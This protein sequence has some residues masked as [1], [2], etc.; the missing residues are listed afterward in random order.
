M[1]EGW[2]DGSRETFSQNSHILSMDEAVSPSDDAVQALVYVIN[3]QMEPS[4][5]DIAHGAYESG[6]NNLP[7]AVEITDHEEGGDLQNTQNDGSCNKKRRRPE[8]WR[9]NVEKRKRQ[10]GQEYEST[11]GKKMPSLRCVYQA[12]QKSHSSPNMASSELKEFDSVF[13]EIIEELTKAGLKLSETEDAYTWFKEVLAYNVPHGKK[14]RGVS[15]V[16]SYRCL[17]PSA[18]EEDLHIARILGWCVELVSF[19]CNIV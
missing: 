4:Q 7:D 18:K 9:R 5:S 6:S 3:D 17:A 11:S 14:N 10:H 8:S 12:L 13:P 16:S 15:V 19:F 2:T 1:A